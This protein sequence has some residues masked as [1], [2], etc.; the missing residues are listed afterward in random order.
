M[1]LRIA[2]CA[3]AAAVL[4]GCSG[5]SGISTSALLSGDAQAKPGDVVATGNDP[6]SRAI[7]VGATSARARKCGFNFDP[8]KLKANFL[9]AE[10]RAGTPPDQVQKADR[11]YDYI[12]N[13][14]TT[15]IARDQ[16]YC[17]EDRTRTVKTDLGRHLAGDFSASKSVAPKD[18]GGL[19]A[20]W[21]DGTGKE[22]KPF[23]YESVFDEHTGRPKN[24]NK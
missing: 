18:S 14:V 5:P 17:S 21:G 13:R 12:A 11:E 23:G 20:G 9:A 6:T 8:V 15:E 2:I 22:E 7:Q 24:S 1:T 3:L 4:A 16:T 19:F 10:T